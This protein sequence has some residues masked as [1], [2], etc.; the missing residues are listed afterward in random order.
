MTYTRGTAVWVKQLTPAHY[1]TDTLDHTASES[2]QLREI[3][4]DWRSETDFVK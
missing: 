2:Y 3:P 1:L 4:T